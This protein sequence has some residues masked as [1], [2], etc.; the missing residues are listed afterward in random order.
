MFSY[1]R[2]ECY[3]KCP[4]Q[5]K[6]RYVDRLKV[7]DD[8][9]DQSPLTVG[10]ALHE[11]IETDFETSINKYLFSYPLLTDKQVEETIK[12]D[13]TSRKAKELVADLTEGAKSVVYEYKLEYEDFI[14]FIDLLVERN[15][16]EYEIYDFKY[17][18]PRSIDKYK[19]SGQL[20][21][22]K[23]YFEKMNPTAK[24][25][26]LGF[27]FCPKT[28]IRQRRSEGTYQFR[29]RLKKEL[30]KLE[31]FLDEVE[32]NTF[33][34]L[35]FQTMKSQILN[36]TDFPKR[37]SSLCKW[38]DYCSYCMNG[39]D[40]MLLKGKEEDFMFKKVWVYGQPFSG[41][42]TFACGS[43]KHYVLSTDGNAEYSTDSYKLIVDEVTQ[44]GRIVTR[45]LAWEVFLEELEKLEA[46]CDYETV[47]VDLV[48]DTY[49]MCRLA[50][51]E[52]L[53]ITHES[54]DSMK[55][56]DKVRTRYLSTMRRLLNLPCNVV[57]I[58]HEDT[59]RDITK[60][61]GSNITSIKPNMQEKVAKKLSG[62][63]AVVARAVVE[64][65]NYTLQTKSDEII[66]GGGRL[67]M[68]GLTLPLDWTE[69]CKAFDEKVKS[70]K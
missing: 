26:K 63:C 19:D 10:T 13:I 58:S 18:S 4:Y 33:K 37:P 25:T 17:C 3:K 65:G 22:Y 11:A 16:N 24:V 29:E 41:K 66:F 2:V 6:L 8:F 44:K 61:N 21:I 51:Y 38:C 15:E 56:W 52:E 43:P 39:E 49:E 62:M 7:L 42:T 46:K 27:I 5:Y 34:V 47:V 67:G 40:W 45:K 35:N 9:D 30:E 57:L 55:A 54:D 50:M 64:D 20:H 59:S 1:S 14:G 68:S 70:R 48:E 23:D 60:R 53:G 69:F 36:T 32:P 12:I 28:F 31:P